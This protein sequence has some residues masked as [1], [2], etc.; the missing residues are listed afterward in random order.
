MWDNFADTAAGFE[1]GDVV[2]ARRG[3]PLQRPLP[4]EPRKLRIAAADEFELADY[5]P[6]PRK[7]VEEL[8]SALVRTRRQL[9]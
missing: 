5:V 9:L 6:H 7:D 4:A 3:M 2:K 8:W 1:Q